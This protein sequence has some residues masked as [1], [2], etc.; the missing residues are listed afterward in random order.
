MK[1][2]TFLI[3]HY[4]NNNIEH[5]EEIMFDYGLK[6]NNKITFNKRININT[7]R[8]IDGINIL[9][10]VS[11]ILLLLLFIIAIIF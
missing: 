5:I 1:F 2:N 3:E 9:I 6:I 11:S 4:K 7:R 10:T 8:D